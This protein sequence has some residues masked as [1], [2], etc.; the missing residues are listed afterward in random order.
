MR[1]TVVGVFDR[2][3]SAKQAAQQLRDSGFGDSVFLTDD[4]SAAP[5][6]G[7]AS[8]AESDDGGVLAHVRKFFA[9]LFSG[10]DESETRPY[11]E[12]LRRGGGVVKVE[13]GEDDQLEIARQALEAAGAVNID[14]RAS[15]WRASGWREGTSLRSEE[16]SS[17][18]SSASSQAAS[19][20]DELAAD[21]STPRGSGRPAGNEDEQVIPVV[22]EDLQV[23]KRAVQKGGVRVY[24]RTVDRPVNE[25]VDLRSEHADVQRHPVDRP[26]S[27]S[28]LRDLGERT[29]EV[30]EMAEEPVVA[31][32]AR[33]VEEVVVGKT[34]EQRSEQISDSVRS[35]E[36]QV[37]PLRSDST[38]E[39]NRGGHGD[40]AHFDANYGSSGGRWEDYEPAYRYGDAVRA[41]ARY[42]GRSWD[43]IEPDVRRDW[44]GRNAGPWERFKD[45]VRHGWERVTD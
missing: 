41:D 22:K 45:A 13:V 26:A 19:A 42:S 7:R 34:T 25:S 36:V 37:E 38:A 21:A 8:T 23:G 28:D 30:R 35:T 20:T 9:G 40:R 14:E 1:Q 29:F 3:A 27:E 43:Q 5:G 16:P 33:V 44:E 10:D 6:A 2:Y 4:V 39:G 15:E 18:A 12:A 11:A 24:A 17:M 31:K 32:Q